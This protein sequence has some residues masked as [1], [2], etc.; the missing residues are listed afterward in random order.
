MCLE[1]AVT[2][3]ENYTLS[4]DILTI[5]VGDTIRRDLKQYNS[6]FSTQTILT[7]F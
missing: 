3:T 6:L 4:L 1:K 7:R 2:K 5:I